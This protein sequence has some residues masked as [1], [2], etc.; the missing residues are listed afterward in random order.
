MADLGYSNCTIICMTFCT[1]LS[2]LHT[3]YDFLFTLCYI[4]ANYLQLNAIANTFRLNRHFR[5]VKTLKIYPRRDN[6]NFCLGI[7]VITC[8]IPNFMFRSVS[9]YVTRCGISFRNFLK[10][11]IAI[12]EAI[13]WISYLYSC[14]FHSS[15]VWES[16]TWV[17]YSTLSLI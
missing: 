16:V 11:P 9:T 10:E 2:L 1:F 14:A 6:R 17:Y 12:H 3:I 15:S 4:Y 13:D 7:M 5:V 8:A